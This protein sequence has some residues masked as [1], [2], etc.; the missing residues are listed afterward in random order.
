MI[1]NAACCPRGS[2]FTPHLIPEAFDI[3]HCIADHERLPSEMAFDG[4]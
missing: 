1:Y 2:G 4:A 3:V